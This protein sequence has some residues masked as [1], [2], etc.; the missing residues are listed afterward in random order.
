M[1]K[2]NANVSRRHSTGSTTIRYVKKAAYTKT[3]M[4]I[5]KQIGDILVI[6]ALCLA[7]LKVI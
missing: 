3:I 4:A 7:I 6:V 2:I 5:G 1:D